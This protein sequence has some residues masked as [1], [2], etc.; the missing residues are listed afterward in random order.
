MSEAGIVRPA[1]RVR[2]RALIV[3]AGTMR[4]LFDCSNW[5]KTFQLI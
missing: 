2:Q 4:R 3:S 1:A 5:Q